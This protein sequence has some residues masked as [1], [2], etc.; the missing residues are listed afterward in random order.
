MLIVFVLLSI[1]SAP[2]IRAQSLAISRVTLI[3][4]TGKSAQRDMTLLVGGNRIAAIRPSNKAR[5]SGGM[6]VV[7]GKGLENRRL[8]VFGRLRRRQSF[9]STLSASVF[10]FSLV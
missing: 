7:D 10:S 2:V 8:R 6:H 9:P 4:G 3:D 5:I 1:L